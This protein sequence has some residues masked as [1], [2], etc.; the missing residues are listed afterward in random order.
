LA[1]CTPVYLKD[2][3]P[4]SAWDDGFLSR[5]ILVYNG[6]QPLTSLF[7]EE[8][9]GEAVDAGLAEELEVIGNLYGK[10]TFTP[11]AASFIDTWH[12]AKGPPRP[13]HPRLVN[14]CARRTAHLI[15][16]SIVAAISDRPK[17]LIE[18]HHIQTALDWLVEAEFYMND[19]FK[20]MSTGGDGQIINDAYHFIYK[21]YMKSK[22]PVSEQSIVNFLMERVPAHAVGRIL[23]VMLKAGLLKTEDV[24]GKGI[25]YK[26]LKPKGN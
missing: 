2:T 5:V 18:K 21:L 1:G 26:P 25:C 20:A 22:Q 19:I 8:E 4:A 10:L 11:E 15:K 24:A 14:Y 12:L 23:E 3:L 16:L 9:R 7:S 13:D 17:L 6:E